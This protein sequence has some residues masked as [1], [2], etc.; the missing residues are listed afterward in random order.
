[1]QSAT[2]LKS[3]AVSSAACEAA[4]AK[5][6]LL[7]ERRNVLASVRSSALRFV[8]AVAYDGTDFCGWQTQLNGQ[9]VQDVLEARLRQIVGEV[10]PIAASGRTDAGVH[11]KRQVFHFSIP[12]TSPSE[13]ASGS[14]KFRGPVFD[15]L[16]APSPSATT[17][18]AALRLCL[19]GKPKNCGLPSTVQ[20]LDVQP[21][22]PLFHAREHCSAKRYVYTVQEG[23]G[24]PFSTRFVWALGR[25]KQLDLAAM[26][27]AAEMLTGVHDFSSFAYI[28][29]KDPRERVKHM[30][31][32]EVERHSGA[33]VCGGG[34]FGASHGGSLVTITAVCDRFL[35]HMMRMIS[36]ALVQVGLGQMPVSRIAELLESPSAIRDGNRL[37]PYR[38]PA[39]GLCLDCCFF[40]LDPCAAAQA[41]STRVQSQEM[42][43]SAETITETIA[44]P[45]SPQSPS[46][47]EAEAVAVLSLSNGRVERSTKPIGIPWP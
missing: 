15:A 16:A 47:S 33:A 43:T 14:M 9:G 28:S 21:A 18:A 6:Q 31:S 35:Q 41:E 36:G 13:S 23:L 37:Q 44:E 38:A 2:V 5:A 39:S 17:V 8:C 27:Q 20:V 40:S 26:R 42:S 45:A 24:D 4:A 1:M 32:L 3:S 46:S 7:L 30:H 10:T 29:K 19:F 22:P 34:P 12:E 25:G 11:A